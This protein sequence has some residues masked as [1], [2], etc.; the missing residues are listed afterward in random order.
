MIRCD[1]ATVE[2]AGVLV[3]DGLSLAV[4]PGQATAVVG[5]TGAG[6]SAL[7]LAAAT[8]LP[9][10]AG[11][12]AIEGLSVRREPRQVRRRIGYVP[13]RLPA[14]PDVRAREFLE[15]FAATA[16]LE[17]PR[18]RAA[19]DRGL[20]LAGLGLRDTTPLDALPAGEAKRLLVARALLHEP[21]VLL[22][23]DPFSGLDPAESAVVARLVADAQLVGRTVLAAIDSADV[24]GC[25]THLA[26][27]REGR[28][29]ATGPAQA[30]AFAA[31]RRWRHRIA[32]PGAAPAAARALAARGIEA[33]AADASTLVVVHDP[34]RGPF[35]DVLASL[36]A[37][38]IPVES[39]AYDPPWPAQL[40]AEPD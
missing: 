6:K 35:A 15:L 14:W 11:D 18:L 30:A 22:L 31:G 25:F 16:G 37:D 40:L 38:G 17:G 10:H 13:D 28:L 4:E 3:V 29:V 5:H 19:V 34:A 2:R 12:I 20:E 1:R 24:P 32:C 7:L 8:A 26:V 27:L 36:V 9:L 23:D 21:P 33:A 39:A